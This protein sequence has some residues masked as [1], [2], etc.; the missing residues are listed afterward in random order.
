MPDPLRI[1]V[2]FDRRVTTKTDK[3]AHA[4]GSKN[5]GSDEVSEFASCGVEFS[6]TLTLDSRRELDRRLELAF[7]VCRE[8]VMREVEP[9]TELFTK[10]RKAFESAKTV[11]E[12]DKFDLLMAE[13]FNEGKIDRRECV[14]LE[15]IAE[16]CRALLVVPL[17]DV[18]TGD[19]AAEVVADLK[20]QL[21]LKTGD[22]IE[23]PKEKKK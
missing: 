6:E 14:W 22:E 18:P 13:R 20:Q 19:G 11:D 23:T 12:L 9:P 8:R 1:T 15:E 4:D 16:D 10:I 17:I 7:A 5:Y 3:P 21:T 2:K